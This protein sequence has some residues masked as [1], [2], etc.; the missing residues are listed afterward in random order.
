MYIDWIKRSYEGGLKLVCVL[1]VTNMFWASRGMGPGVKP[2]LPIDDESVA[3]MAI[4]SFKRIVARNSDWMEIALTPQDARRIILSNKLAVVLGV[5]M[6][7][8]GNF[9]DASYVFREPYAMPPS[10]PLT[11]LSSDA[12][13]ARIQIQNKIQEYYDIGIRQVTPLHYISGLFGGTAVFRYQFGMI[14]SAFT[15]KPYL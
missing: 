1:G 8:F 9:K 13:E 10:K 15:G 11:I 7:N 3:L 6:D 14:Q 2:E 12:V 5:E 4:D